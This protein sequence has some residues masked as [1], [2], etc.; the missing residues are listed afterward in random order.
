MLTLKDVDD[1]LC[2]M[3]IEFFNFQKQLSA[4]ADERK[5]RKQNVFAILNAKL[6]FWAS[7]ITCIL[8]YFIYAQRNKKQ[9]GKNKNTYC[10]GDNF[11]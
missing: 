2:A 6:R 3:I 4:D 7:A 9:T 11:K 10:G 1:W 5:N 8:V